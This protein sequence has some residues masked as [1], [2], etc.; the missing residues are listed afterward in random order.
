MGGG[1]TQRIKNKEQRTS[2]E[3]PMSKQIG[4]DL[5]EMFLNIL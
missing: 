4:G 1:E 5:M 2:P 3:P